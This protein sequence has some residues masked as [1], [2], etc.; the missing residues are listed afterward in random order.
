MTD[1]MDIQ[2]Y[3]GHMTKT[4]RMLREQLSLVDIVIELLDARVPLSSKNPD[5]DTLASGKRRVVILNKADLADRDANKRWEEY[6]AAL[7]WGVLLTDS[8]DRQ[9][10]ARLIKLAQ[11]ILADKIEKQQARGRRDASVR[12]MVV[13]IPNVG[14]ST[15]I[16]GLAGN[17]RAHTADRPGVTRGRQWINVRPGFDMLDTPGILWPK[18]EDKQVGVKLAVT[19][20]VSDTILD[21][22]TLAASLLEMLA[23]IKPQA[24]SERY[25]VEAS[26]TTGGGL[27]LLT[28]IGQAR[29]FKMKGGVVDTE[30]AAIIVL[31][32]FRGG[33]LGRITLELP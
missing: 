16:N 21:K 31:D 6:F 5:I 18:F 3:P 4:V 23:E 28:A 10:S 15:F 17:Q 25:K 27:S 12:A 13:G 1:T 8:R 32:E 2:W 20:A 24:V 22:V 30:R 14:K 7:G 19:G 26:N 33:K 9:S 29:G 11:D